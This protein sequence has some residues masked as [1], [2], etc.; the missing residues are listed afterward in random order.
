MS[1]HNKVSVNNHFLAPPTNVRASHNVSG[2]TIEIVAN[3]SNFNLSVSVCNNEDTIQ[4]R[5]TTTN[6]EENSKFTINGCET[7][8][9]QKS[10]MTCNVPR[11]K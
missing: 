5:Y 6:M 1:P 11:T 7:S 10:F 2:S 3:N 9:D 8:F 4:Q